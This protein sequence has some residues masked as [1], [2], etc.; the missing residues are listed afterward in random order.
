MMF[1]S[2]ADVQMLFHLE[3]RLNHFVISK[4]TPTPYML[5]NVEF[6]EAFVL[7]KVASEI[8]YFEMNSIDVL[9]K[10]VFVSDE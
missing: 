2:F 3:Q 7:T 10:I 9:F 4:A 1:L 6:E 5:D 8:A